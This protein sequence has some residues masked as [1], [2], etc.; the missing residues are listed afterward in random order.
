M[1][2]SSGCELARKTIDYQG[3]YRLPAMLKRTG[4]VEYVVF[5]GPS[6]PWSEDA[7]LGWLGCGV[8]CSDLMK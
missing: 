6:E 4:T 8:Y 5:Q 2:Q 7:T 3:D 1:H